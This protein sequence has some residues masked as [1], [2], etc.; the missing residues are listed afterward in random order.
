MAKR[1]EPHSNDWTIGVDLGGTK[2][3][4]ALVDSKGCVIHQAIRPVTPP[5]RHEFDPRDPYRPSATDVRKHVAYVVESMT[6]TIVECASA[7]ETKDRRRIRGVGLASAGPMDL[8]QGLLIDSSNFKG[9]K[10]VAIVENLAKACAKRT[11]P[12]GL[13]KSASFQNDAVAAALGEGWVGV[14]KAKTTYVMI[15]IGT[16]IGTGVILNGRPAQSQ[17]RGCEWGH[18]I[19]DSRG[20]SKRLDDPDQSSPDA[21][22]SGT[23]LV[24]QAQR[25]GYSEFKTA[26]LIAEAAERGDRRA[27]DLLQ[28]CSEALASLFYTL[29]LGFNPE[30]FAVSGGMLAM[31]KF[32]L[33]QAIGMYRDAIRV[34]YPSFEKPIKVSRTGTMAGIIGAARLP[35]L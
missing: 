34:K 3:L 22:A 14:A 21:I 35:R 15:T 16:G 13:K 18:L 17:G 27:Q 32:F 31:Q 20:F 1:I 29:S 9:W 25:H 6:D 26:R 10:R 24:R 2:V 19:C 28:E 7:L 11:L 5:D 12:S 23:G 33:P 4:S 30:V 8:G